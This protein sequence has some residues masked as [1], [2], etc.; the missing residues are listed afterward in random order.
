M[1]Q[2]SGLPAAL[3]AKRIFIYVCGLFFIATGIAFS[4]RSG[5]GVA[6]VGS[7]ANVLYQIGLSRGLPERIFNL[8]NWTIAVY[9]VYI[10]AQIV[11][12]GK[13][14]RPIQL[15]QIVVSILFGYLVNLTS[16]LLSFLP[17]AGNYAVRMLY[18]L[19]SIP[20]V[21]AG[22][23]LYLTPKLIPTPG[24]GC[25]V[26]IAELAHTSVAAGKTIF[27]CT[28]VSISVILSLVYFHGLVGVREGTVISALTTGFVMRQLQ[29]PFQAPLTRFVQR[30]ESA[31]QKE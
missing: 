9:C 21:A 29:K 19:I 20:F 8:G 24:E 7:P 28:V 17:S 12:L 27:D 30:G 3:W 2:K 10:L 16:S 22:V 5:L 11:M 14:F 1:K 31:D 23:M 13:R 4:A 6:P 25:A 15:L 26:A 18:L